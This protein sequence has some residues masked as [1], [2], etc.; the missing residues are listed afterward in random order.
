MVTIDRYDGYLQS[1]RENDLYFSFDLVEENE[2][3]KL[4][5]YMS[6]KKLL[7]ANQDMDGVVITDSLIF[8]GAIDYLSSVGR[9]KDI[10]IGAFGAESN[11]FSKDKHRVINVDVGSM[12]IGEFSFLASGVAESASANFL[13]SVNIIC[14]I[15]QYGNQPLHILILCCPACTKSY[16]MLS[17]LKSLHEFETYIIW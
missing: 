14:F 16:N 8:S 3:N 7:E 6:M 17:V 9:E 4:N 11:S 1:I 5:G 2:F 12:R 15:L 13:P 10:M